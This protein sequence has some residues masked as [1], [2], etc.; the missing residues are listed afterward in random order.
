MSATFGLEAS[1]KNYIEDKLAI[2]MALSH[3]ETL[4]GSV[5]GYLLSEPYSKFG[6]TFFKIAIKGDL[7]AGIEK[8]F[9]DMLEKYH[10]SNPTNK[11]T[12]FMTDYFATK[13]CNVKIK[14]VSP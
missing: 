12:K 7:Q 13:G 3:M 11:F 2:K 5:N 6:W 8:K 4:V 10:E 14:S 9:A 1:T